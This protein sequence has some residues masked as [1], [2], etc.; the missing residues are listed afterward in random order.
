VQDADFTEGDSFSDEMQV[1]LDMIGCLDATPGDVHGCLDATPGAVH[2]PAE[3]MRRRKL[4][5]D[6]MR[7]ISSTYRSKKA[8]SAPWQ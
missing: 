2:A 5:D 1:N 8:I 3:I 7:T 6:T 4:V